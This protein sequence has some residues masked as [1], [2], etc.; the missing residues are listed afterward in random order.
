LIGLSGKSNDMRELLAA[1]RA[2][3]SAADL[4]VRAFCHRAKKYLGAYL[5]ILGGADALIFGGGIGEHSPEVREVICA[6]MDW[7]GLK[8]DR[9]RNL[10]VDEPDWRIN[11][12][13]SRIEVWVVHVDEAMVIGRDVVRRL[14]SRY[15]RK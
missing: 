15:A 5:A 6:G 4:A 10:G 3:D 7:A 2:G 14:G 1:A 8:L 9:Q 11:A 13:D 12:H